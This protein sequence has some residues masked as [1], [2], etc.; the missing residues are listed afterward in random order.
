MHKQT[1][2]Y[3]P[4]QYATLQV[5][6]ALRSG[7]LVRLDHCEVCRRTPDEIRAYITERRG[8]CKLDYSPI[9]AHHFAGYDQP[10][11]VWWVCTECNGMLWGKHDGSLSLEE[12]RAM[13]LQQR[14]RTPVVLAGG[15]VFHP[16]LPAVNT[17]LVKEL[18][19]SSR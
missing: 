15:R 9:H 19:A 8:V 2:V 12:A 14:C 13:W 3:T 5:R 1:R 17:A 16:L 18:A 10:L 6:L 4:S 11:N 7:R